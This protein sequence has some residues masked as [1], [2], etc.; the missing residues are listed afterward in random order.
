M[1]KQSLRRRVLR[2]LRL[3]CFGLASC[4][5]VFAQAQNSAPFGARVVD[6]QLRGSGCDMQKSSVVLSPDAQDL[7]ILFSDYVV[8]IGQG[9]DQ[10]SALQR[11]KECQVNIQL[12]IPDGWQ[13]A[14]RGV[15]YRGF[16]N[17]SAQ[18]TAFHRFS[19]L[20]EGAP[21]V[22]MREAS[23]RGPLNDDYYIRN[24]IR[25]ERIT[26]S[27]CLSGLTQVRLLSQLGVTLNPRHP[28]RSLTQ[29]MLDSQ[30]TSIK[31]NLSI[32]WRRCSA[33]RPENPRPPADSGPVRPRPRP[34]RFGF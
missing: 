27:R 23:L 17:L 6:V 4:L 16:V 1:L 21:I 9:T 13:M 22:S 11:N 30:D 26:W 3:L 18:G 14:F 7:S 20:Q 33:A 31:Q 34:P 12:D 8:E 10:P 15:D 19:I 5:G 2:C 25:P 28:D 32:S 29:I 24:E